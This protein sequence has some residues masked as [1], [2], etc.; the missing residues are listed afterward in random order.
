MS[1]Q[2]FMQLWVADFVG[3]TLHLSSSE[4]GQYLLLLMAMWRNGGTL[5][6]DPK[7][8]ARVARSAVSDAVMAFFDD[9]T[10]GGITQKR[11]CAELERARKKSKALSENG[12]AGAAAKALKNNTPPSANA[13]ATLKHTQN[14]NHL[15]TKV[16]KEP[17]KKGSQVPDDW[18]PKPKTI[19]SLQTKEGFQERFIRSEIPRFRDYHRAKGSKF[20]DHEAAFRNWM[21]K[22]K[23]FSANSNVAIGK[24]GVVGGPWKPFVAEPEP[25]KPPE[26]ERARQ[27]ERVMRKTGW[28]K[29]FP[30]TAQ[31]TAQEIKSWGE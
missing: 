5:P 28:D 22:A 19:A 29:R 23:E 13:S 15:A 1:E 8:L 14:Q 26:E 12:R 16:A 4:I 25:V 10:T 27:V 20:C 17:T 7:K 9:D 18:E 3:D 11:L 21:R 24:T 31:A 30:R 2:P 6:S